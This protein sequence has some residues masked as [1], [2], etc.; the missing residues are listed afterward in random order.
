MD[1]KDTS[2]SVVRQTFKNVKSVQFDDNE[3]VFSTKE[4]VFRFHENEVPDKNPKFVADHLKKALGLKGVV[5][6]PL[7]EGMFEISAII[8]KT[9]EETLRRL[10]SEYYSQFLNR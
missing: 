2:E 7:G 3:A 10:L 4:A 9:Q 8:T 1:E 6:E 5:T